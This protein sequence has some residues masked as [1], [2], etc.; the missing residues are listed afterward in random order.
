MWLFTIHGLFSVVAAKRLGRVMIRARVRSHLLSL[1][2]A[3]GLQGP[4]HKTPKSDYAFRMSVST[5][6]W[7]R[8]SRIL[9]AESAAIDNFKACADEA[10]QRGEL[11][12]QTASA[13]HE[14]H[15]VMA[16]A[17]GAYGI[18]P[19]PIRRRRSVTGQFAGTVQYVHGREA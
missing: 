13:Y 7:A 3:T 2:R 6:N 19:R 12:W 1:R 4:I 18:K 17:L 11:D 14:A 5:E 15:A 16:D 10:A 9:A 8:A